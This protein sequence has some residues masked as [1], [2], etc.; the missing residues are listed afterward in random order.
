MFGWIKRLCRGERRTTAG[1]VALGGDPED[2]ERLQ[3]ELGAMDAGEFV[4]LVEAMGKEPPPAPFLPPGLLPPGNEEFRRA[5]I[6]EAME[7]DS[8]ARY[9]RGAAPR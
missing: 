5:R 4:E 2:L 6:A 9:M 8:A 3:D 1:E 7:K